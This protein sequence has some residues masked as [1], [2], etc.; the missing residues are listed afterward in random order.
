MGMTLSLTN[1]TVDCDVQ[2]GPVARWWAT[3][4]A[5]EMDGD[6]ET[7]ARTW[8]VLKDWGRR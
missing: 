1:V 8:H 3:A 7:A 5:A 2:P 4:L 6:W